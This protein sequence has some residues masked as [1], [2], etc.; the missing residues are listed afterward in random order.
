MK[1]TTSETP[2]GH[3]R[4]VNYLNR[5]I[6]ELR[7]RKSQVA[8]ASEAGFKARNMLSMI[9]SGHAKLPLDRVPALAFALDC[10]PDL[11]FRMALEQMTE[12]S[13]AEAI[14][15]IFTEVVSENEKQWLRVI[16]EAS[17]NADPRLTSRAERTLR[18]IFE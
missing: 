5:R 2:Y 14:V 4:L 15:N 6:L 9:K 11:L 16:R 10:D 3:T 12:D 17:N 8:I 7:E 18:G 1:K 13:T